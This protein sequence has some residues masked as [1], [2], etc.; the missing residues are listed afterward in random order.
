MKRSVLYS[1]LAA[2]VFV[3][4]CRKDDDIKIPDL[5]RV[6]LP[7]V[8]IDATSD[9]FISPVAPAN[10]KGKFSVDMYFKEDI[11]P[12]K[13][14]IV[15]RKNSTTTK[16][17]RPNI[18]T[19]PT[20]IEVTGQELITLFGAP[21]TGG[22]VFEFGADVTTQGGQVFQAFPAGGVGHA[23]S[24]FN[25]PGANAV[26]SFLTPCAFDASK[27][28]GDFEVVSDEWQDY[29]A[30]TV[31]PV[32]VVSP[33]QLSFEYNVDAGSAVPIIM[34]IN[35]ADNSIT[36]ASQTY[37]TYGG[38]AYTAESVA[39]PA[40][41]VNPCDLSLSVRLKHST[42]GFTGNYTIKLKKKA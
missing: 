40:S 35:P 14:D 12:Q 15:V 34:T 20:T 2:L 22:D 31:I 3:T 8:T 21:I 13:L 4:G 16:V 11:K 7:L 17:L 30:G 9:K 29:K 33:T 25:Q 41:A 37:G 36:V 32:K 6:P 19:Y 26:V 1:I 42:T 38:D 28:A 5:I 27:Y 23:S 39:G 10:F 18:T 24:V